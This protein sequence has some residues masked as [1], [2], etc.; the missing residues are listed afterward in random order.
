M[1][2][3]TIYSNIYPDT[4][5]RFHGFG[6]I[7]SMWK[8]SVFKL[9]WHDLLVFLFVYGIISV[10]YRFV[11]FHY[12]YHREMFE[13]ICVYMGQFSNMIPITFLTGFYVSQVVSRWWDQFMSLPWPEDVA[14]RLV[15]CCPGKVKAK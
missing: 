10:I 14:L 7:F 11:L 1:S 5:R 13:L 15:T 6:K 2:D 12:P 3:K 4:S 8:G 9:I